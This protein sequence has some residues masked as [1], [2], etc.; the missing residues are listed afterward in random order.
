MPRDLFPYDPQDTDDISYRETGDQSRASHSR[1]STAARPGDEPGD[2][3]KPNAL[4]LERDD[5]P[6][7]YEMR[8][9]TFLLRESELHALAELGKF[10]VIAASDLARHAYAGDRSRMERDFRRL[11][12]QSLVSDRTLEISGRKTLRAISLT[13][14]GRRLLKQTGRLS[15]EQVV[16]H[17]LVKPR[18]AKHDADLY[19]LYYKEAARIERHSGKPIRVVLDFEMKRNLNRGRVALGAEKNNPEELDRLAKSHGLS[20]VDGKIPLPDLRIEYQTKAGELRHVDLELATRH[21]R[22]AG[23][24]AKAKAGFSLHSFR[25]DA[26]RL[27]RI[28]NDRELTAEILAL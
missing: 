12:R 8:D 28:L 15:E 6:Q 25:E 27:R 22:P 5:A 14:T 23:L 26:S 10:R 17:G 20:V 16:Y 7:A 3:A 19:R 2:F 18:E 24:T 11:Q 4:P 13:K 9:R 21:Y 1:T